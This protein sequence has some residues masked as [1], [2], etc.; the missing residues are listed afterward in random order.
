MEVARAPPT[1]WRKYDGDP[2]FRSPHY[3]EGANEGLF[4]AAAG[5]LATPVHP[6]IA[7]AIDAARAVAPPQ[8]LSPWTPTPSTPS[9]TPSATTSPPLSPRLTPVSSRDPAD[10]FRRAWPWRKR[11]FDRITPISAV[12]SS[13][14][15][16]E[17]VSDWRDR[18]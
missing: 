13:G 8:L 10:K 6:R 14:G 11:V 15:S 5:I 1:H 12:Y 17:S 18:D 4:A 2:L 16:V 9:L 3:G 7:R